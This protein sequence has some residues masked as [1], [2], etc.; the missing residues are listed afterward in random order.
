MFAVCVCV[1]VCVCLVAP[2]SF[3]GLFVLLFVC[4]RGFCFYG[5]VRLRFGGSEVFGIP[6][7]VARR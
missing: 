3:L 1:C 5:M 7:G 4:V 2:L 6:V